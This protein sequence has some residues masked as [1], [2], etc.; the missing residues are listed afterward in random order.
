MCMTRLSVCSGVAI[1]ASVL[2]QSIQAELLVHEGF[3]YG[4]TA[5]ID[6]TCNGGVG[7]S[8]A[9]SSTTPID[10]SS[11]SLAYPAGG[12]LTSV[13]GAASD[14]AVGG[15]AYR[16]LAN[17]IEFDSDQTLYTSFLFKHFEGGWKGLRLGVDGAYDHADN[18]NTGITSSGSWLLAW[19][20]YASVG[21]WGP[22]PG[23]TYLVTE[24]LVLREG[25]T[26][27][28]WYVKIYSPTDTIG[29]EPTTWDLH[30]SYGLSGSYD[31]IW[32]DEKSDARGAFDEIRIGTTWADVTGVPE[33]SAI[34]M[35]LSML[36]GMLIY[37]W[38]RK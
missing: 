38:R 4:A 1:L 16:M 23:T 5:A 14:L 25:A 19:R 3:D 7:F 27:D 13:G 30:G 9:W 28:D 32:L 31:R 37:A 22:T 20:V 12:S 21:T 11:S 15:L 24:K 33:P 29:S 10:L 6:G 8:G 18:L 2:A 26:P 35:V 34:V 17:P 36:C